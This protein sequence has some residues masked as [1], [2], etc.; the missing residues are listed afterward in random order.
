MTRARAEDLAFFVV[1]V[2]MSPVDY[3]ALTVEQH[4]AI[5]TAWR[6]HNSR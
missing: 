2:G 1:C 6:R 5:A 4:N 3:W